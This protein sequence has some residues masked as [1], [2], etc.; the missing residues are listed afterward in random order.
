MTPFSFTERSAVRERLIEFA[1][2]DGRVSGGAD[3]GSAA[4]GLQDR[5]S[6]IDI[7]FGL[8]DGNDIEV[9]LKEWTNIL[10]AEFGIAHH[11]DVRSGCAIYRVIL[12]HNGLE[13]DLSMAPEKDFGARGP[14]F[15]LLF[16][17]AKV[18]SGF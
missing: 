7:T 2:S 1:Q 12:F 17:S 6:D 10:D 14:N 15:S 16:G 18:S 11:F 5:W 4:T 13:L 9:V 3:I 8:K